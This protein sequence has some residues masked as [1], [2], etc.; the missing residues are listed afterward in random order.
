MVVNE[1]AQGNKFYDHE[2]TTIKKLDAAPSG[3]A[4][5][6]KR[7]GT[8]SKH[9]ALIDILKQDI[10]DVNMSKELDENGEPLVVD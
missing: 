5:S 1:D 3:I 9:Q 10:W 7:P 4:I 6:G 2:M 8:E